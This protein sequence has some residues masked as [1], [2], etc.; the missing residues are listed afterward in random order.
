MGKFVEPEVFILAETRLT[1]HD[2][3]GYY[4]FLEYLGVPGW[5]TDAHSEAEELM[6]AAGKLCYLSFSTDLNKNLTKVGTRSNYDYLQKGIIAT[7]HGSV[8]EHAT[9]SI[10]FMNVSR[11]FT[12]ELVRHRPGS[13]YSQVSGRYVRTDSVDMFLPTVIKENEEAVKI[14]ERASK[15]MEDNVMELTRVFNIDEMKTQKEFSLKKILT[16][17]F[18]RIIGNGQTN[19]IIATYNHRSLR[20]ILEVRTSQHAEEEIRIAFYKL[21]KLLKAKYPA[22]YGD[23]KEGEFF[24]GIPEI[25]FEHSKV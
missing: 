11:V 20:H 21:Y 6:E 25:T 12:H 16:S 10:A 3:K 2:E 4:D 13:A 14:F 22:V 24:S 23:A 15:Q 18:R 19:H 5:A 8:L 1:Y 9:I 7:K 17:A